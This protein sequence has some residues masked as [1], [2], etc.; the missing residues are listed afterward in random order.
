MRKK[1]KHRNGGGVLAKVPGYF[2]LLARR[3]HGKM[4]RREF[5]E[6]ANRLIA[7]THAGKSRKSEVG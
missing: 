1:V 5:K 2:S 3:S 6:A 4:S 7:A